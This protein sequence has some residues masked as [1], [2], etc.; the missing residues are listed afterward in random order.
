M[1]TL[2]DALAERINEVGTAELDVDE[3]VSQGEERL[4]RRR[5]TVALG[6]AAA[7]VIVIALAL[8]GTALIGSLPEDPAP[9]GHN[10][11]HKTD[12]NSTGETTHSRPLV[13]SDDIDYGGDVIRV[14]TI[15][16]GNRKV[17][18]NQNLHTIRGWPLHVTDAGVVYAE[19]DGSVWFTDGHEPRRIAEHHCG[20]TEPGNY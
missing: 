18:I 5:L 2:R 3:L 14:G 1:N 9:G 15:H 20:G 17:D 16:V 13:Y 11:Q 19:D 10:D 6:S 8:G 7:V 12:G 4:R